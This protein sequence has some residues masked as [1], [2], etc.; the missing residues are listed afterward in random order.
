MPHLKAP[1]AAP[2]TRAHRSSLHTPH[3]LE[4]LN[5]ILPLSALRALADRAGMNARTQSQ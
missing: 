1:A 3:P 2:L 5:G 4:H